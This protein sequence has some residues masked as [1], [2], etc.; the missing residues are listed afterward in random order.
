MGHAL[1]VVPVAVVTS[2]LTALWWFVGLAALTSP[3]RGGVVAG[4]LRPMSLSVGGPESHLAV[5][6]GLTA[7]AERAVFAVVLGCSA[8]LTLPLVTRACVAVQA[9]LGRLLPGDPGAPLRGLDRSGG[10]WRA[11]QGPGAAAEVVALRRL[12]RDI[13]DGPQQRL[14]RLAMD[15]GRAEYHFEARPQ[16][17]REAIAGALVQAEETIAELRALSRGVAPPLLTDRGLPAAVAALAA[18]CVIPV[19]LDLGRLGHR[20]GAAVE[21]AAYFVVAEALANVAKHS[22]AGHCEIGLRHGGGV[23][24]V[25]VRDDGV[26]GAAVV[27]GHGL[28]GL[29]ERLWGVGGRLRVVSPEGGP[30]VVTG[31][32]PCR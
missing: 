4:P 17:A 19:E 31:E 30:T 25:W 8:L 7:P 12:E 5:S 21:T 22:R 24:R 32:V 18:Y 14:V 11:V 2:S 3:V 26:G 10:G 1:L 28:R 27:K 16:V 23:L 29:E 9:G 6:L 13:H 15:L 20:P